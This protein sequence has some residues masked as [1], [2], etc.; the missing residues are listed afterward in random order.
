MCLRV[1]VGGGGFEHARTSEVNLFK[2]FGPPR[3]PS[4]DTDEQVLTLILSK[5]QIR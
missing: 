5:G 1:P 2:D 4:G 3:Q